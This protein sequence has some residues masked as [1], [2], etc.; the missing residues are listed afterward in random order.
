MKEI[1]CIGDWGDSTRDVYIQEYIRRNNFDEFYL[2]GDNFYPSGVEST[3]DSQWDIKF[4]TLFPSPKKKYVCLGNHD[5]LG[6]VFSQ[7]EKTFES[8]NN[9]W[10]LPYFF[11]D[12]IDEENSIHTFFIDSQLASPDITSMLLLSCNISHK[13]Q[14]EYFN[15]VFH[16]QNKQYEWL[17]KKLKDSSSKWK[18]IC[19]HYPIYSNGPHIISKEYQD[20]MTPLLKKYNVDFYF[21]GHEHNNQIIFK[22][23]TYFIISGGIF[24]TNSYKI[25]KITEPTL[26]SSISQ[27]FFSIKIF[28][29]KI[30]VYHHNIMKKRKEL[31]CIKIKK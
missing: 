22:D 23:K 19:G 12:I 13:R 2:L 9:N 28:K 25:E 31:C 8:N 10:N 6:N 1:L 30:E 17:E 29:N 14:Q 7:I 18:I 16:L 21:N 15:L 27:G 26:F 11:Y 3:E 20:R 4:K 24:S 5:Y